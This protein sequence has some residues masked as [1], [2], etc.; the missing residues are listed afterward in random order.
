MGRKDFLQETRGAFKLALVSHR[1]SNYLQVL[2]FCKAAAFFLAL[3][4]AAIYECKR[5]ATAAAAGAGINRRAA[6]LE[7]LDGFLK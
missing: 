4:A 2:F 7:L 3:Q 1:G 6:F 5:G